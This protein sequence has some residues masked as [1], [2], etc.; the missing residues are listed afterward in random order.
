MKVQILREPITSILSPD[1]CQRFN[2]ACEDLYG[3]WLK[4]VPEASTCYFSKVVQ[5]GMRP[6][7]PSDISKEDLLLAR[8]LFDVHSAMAAL[9]TV[10][11]WRADQLV[12]SLVSSLN[13]WNLSASAA[14]VRALLETAA[15]FAVESDEIISVWNGL[16]TRRVK[17]VDEL[18][19]VRQDLFKAS[20]QSFWGTRL[21]PILD[22]VKKGELKS[23]IQRTNI[24]T[25]V[26]KACK[27][28]GTPQLHDTYEVLCDAVHP[29]WGSGE[30][31]WSETGVN[32]RLRQMRIVLNKKA[33]GK[34]VG[35]AGESKDSFG[36]E[37]PR[38]IFIAGTWSI[39]R[40]GADLQRFGQMVKDLCLTGKVFHLKELDYFGLVSPTDTYSRCACG[41]GAKSRFCNHTFG[42]SS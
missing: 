26:Q 10:K 34:G 6:K 5:L 27:R 35:V 33:R 31:F 24:L 18:L 1:T 39:A 28:W 32:E 12:E 7:V 40:L 25:L 8:G 42:A 15:A 36:S 11:S 16:K 2:S 9:L 41:S 30:C 19:A 17:T 23:N 37:L 13:D 29:S 38:A 22:Q 20:V 21:S 14:L 3:K 4:Q